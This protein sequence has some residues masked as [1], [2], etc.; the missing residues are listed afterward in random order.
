M[1]RL[2]LAIVLNGLLILGGASAVF[3]KQGFYLGLA[4]PYN[5][6]G[7]DFDGESFILRGH[8]IFIVEGIIIQPEIDGAL[9][10][11]ILLGCGFTPAWA[12]ELDF[13][14]S[15]HDAEWLG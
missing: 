13:L 11:G 2:M 8:D 4:I 7:G 9:G 5:T 12:L 3:A 14:T 15:S 6:I 10:F 1:R